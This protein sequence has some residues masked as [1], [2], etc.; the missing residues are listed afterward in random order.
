MCRELTK[1]QPPHRRHREA[2]RLVARRASS[3]TG[4]SR[5]S[6]RTIRV[7]EIL[8]PGVWRK[9]ALPEPDLRTNPS[10]YSRK[11]T[12]DRQSHRRQ[13]ASSLTSPKSKLADR[14][15]G[16]LAIL[17]THHTLESGVSAQ[18]HRSVDE[19][20][21]KRFSTYVEGSLP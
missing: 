6:S 8:D 20:A 2:A 5:R 12:T 1:N 4:G 14:V 13:T 17:R 15:T 18:I 10:Q 9:S 7:I 19:F 16:V 11:L 21:H 3:Q